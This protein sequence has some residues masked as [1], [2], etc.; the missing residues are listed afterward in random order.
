M[1]AEQAKAQE[2][3]AQQ[4]SEVAKADEFAKAQQALADAQTKV[5]A[6]QN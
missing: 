6:L 4:A 5:N 3:A 2:L 1:T